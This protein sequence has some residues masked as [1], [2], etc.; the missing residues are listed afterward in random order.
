MPCALKQTA[1][2]HELKLA[3]ELLRNK[4]DAQNRFRRQFR[5]IV[6]EGGSRWDA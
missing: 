1:L 2:R 5:S 6:G 3:L 4:Q